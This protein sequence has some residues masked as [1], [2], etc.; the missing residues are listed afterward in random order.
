MG[1][2]V[3]WEWFPLPLCRLQSLTLV[4]DF[5][6]GQ[7]I[8]TIYIGGRGGQAGLA[9]EFVMKKSMPTTYGDTSQRWNGDSGD[10]RRW[11]MGMC[12]LM[13]LCLLPHIY[14]PPFI[15]VWLCSETVG[16]SPCFKHHSS[17]SEKHSLSSLKCNPS[18][19]TPSLS[20]LS[21]CGQD[22]TQPPHPLVIT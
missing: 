11:R 14:H 8:L 20:R 17:T 7:E 2:K 4:S 18:F 13:G 21:L 22:K 19:R 9:L 3:G 15:V 10:S 5:S 12:L 16:V 1:L 6:S